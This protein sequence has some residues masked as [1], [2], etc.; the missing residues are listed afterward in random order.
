M[1]ANPSEMAAPA[2]AA[3]RLAAAGPLGGTVPPVATDR[4]GVTAQLGSTGQAADR[5]NI[6]TAAIAD[7]EDLEVADLPGLAG[8]AEVVGLRGAA[9]LLEVA[10]LPGVEGPAGGP[11]RP[12]Q[13]PAARRVEGPKVPGSQ[14]RT[15]AVPNRRA[16][17][18]MT[19][20]CGCYFI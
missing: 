15:V 10:G 12:S 16:D 9:G 18:G 14:D 20:N 11:N 5:V 8:L 13:N 6:P 3:G 1:S 19:S 7:R 4:P 17:G 2:E